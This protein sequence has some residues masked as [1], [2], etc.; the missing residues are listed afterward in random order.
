M[1]TFYQITVTEEDAKWFYM[2]QDKE[3]AIKDAKDL[4]KTYE[5]VTVED[6]VTGRKIF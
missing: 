4:K 3:D 5:N 6:A 1:T 2:T